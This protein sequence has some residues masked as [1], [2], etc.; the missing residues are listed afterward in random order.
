[1]KKLAFNNKKYLKIQREEINKRI[2]M[3]D[4]KLYLEFGGKLF[5]DYHASR[6]LPGFEPDSKLQMLLSMKEKVEIVIVVNTNDINSNKVRNDYGITYQS[7]VERLIDAYKDVGLY[8]GS[9][10]FSFYY[11]S[12]LVSAFIKK[13]NK[14]GIKTY[15]H[16]KINGYPHNI[17]LIVSED[18]L[19]K[20]EYI[21][22][23]RPLVVITAP[24][25]GSGKMATCL[26]QLYHDNKNGIRAGYAKYETFPIWNLALNHP[27]NLA[28]EAATVDLK[29]VNMIDP[30][31]L[32]QFDV[33][34]VN[35]NRDVEVFPLL[36][37]IFEK[38]YGESP[39][40]SPTMM[41]VNMVGFAIQNEQV[42]IKCSQDEIIRRYYQA[43][44][45][46]Y[47][48]KY[49]D[50]CVE[51]I[52]MLMNNLGISVDNRKCVQAALKKSE[53]AK[54]PAMAIEL[55]NGK[56]VTAKSSD[57]F[58]SS[59]ALI[60]NAIKCL[61]KI[62]DSIPLISPTV[63]KPIQSL[64]QD[65]LKSN[66]LK[67]HAEEVLTALAI[68]ATTNSLSDFALRQVAKLKNC[69]AHSSVIISKA[70]LST[71]KKIGIEVTEES[72]SNTK[73]LYIK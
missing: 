42:A 55:P 44:K 43:K 22:T 3:F 25:P 52:E 7:D 41:G 56:V 37:A 62:D 57:S 61:G 39:Y 13:L 9:V 71:L 31:H 4:D 17:P 50:S 35:Y 20:N 64:K 28:Y 18:G 19:G 45:N 66:S 49:D 51:K 65:I 2:K 15:R 30:F 24:G 63:I 23:S 60:L 40:L 59:A 68:Q 8:V 58:S 10:V 47:Y 11:E 36:K 14:N 16:Y 5:D 54:A 6:V 27:L 32:E 69:Q 72:V 21:E 33:K 12:Q 46:N 67:M 34:A 1:M 70:D 73:K 53:K 26:S 29:D 38:I 48:D